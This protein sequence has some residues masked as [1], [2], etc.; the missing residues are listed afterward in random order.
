[1]PDTGQGCACSSSWLSGTALTSV[2]DPE[3]FDS[4]P[5][6]HAAVAAGCN[7]KPS[8]DLYDSCALAGRAG[9]LSEVGKTGHTAGSQ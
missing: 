6:G 8:D 3:S 5:E 2:S 1:M 4:D 7:K 9:S